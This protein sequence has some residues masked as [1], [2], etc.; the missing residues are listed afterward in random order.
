M[1]SR[2]SAAGLPWVRVDGIPLV[3]A[4]ADMFATNGRMLAALDVTA[5]G[6]YLDY[7]EVWTGSADPQAAATPASTCNNWGAAT[8]LT[9]VQGRVGF[10]DVRA[11]FWD[12]FPPKDC[13]LPSAVYCLQQ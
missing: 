2:F 7:W 6:A 8:G 1:A 10:T 5:S 3:V 4:A 12:L 11:R 9:G 13:V